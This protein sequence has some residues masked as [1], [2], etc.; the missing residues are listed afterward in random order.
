M[1]DAGWLEATHREEPLLLTKNIDV[2]KI[3]LM[4]EQLQR[5]SEQPEIIN[6]LPAPPRLL[7]KKSILPT[8]KKMRVLRLTDYRSVLWIP[9][10]VK[11]ATIGTLVVLK[12]VSDGFN[13]ETVGIVSTFASQ[14]CISVENFLLL[15][16]NR[17]QRALPG[18]TEHR[19]PRA[20]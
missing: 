16:R 9:L 13:K 4:K 18:R 19:Q 10:V 1:A 3:A 6:P 20:A 8:N 11:N 7:R 2:D 5:R 12:E 14:A 15:G 17:D